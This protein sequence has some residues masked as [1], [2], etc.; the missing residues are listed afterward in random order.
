VR[1]GVYPYYHSDT[2]M[3]AYRAER[4][5]RMLKSKEKLTPTD[6]QKFQMDEYMVHAEVIVPILIGAIGAAVTSMSPLSKTAYEEL[7]KWDMI[8]GTDSVGSSIFHETYRVL[9]EETF[10]DDLAPGLYKLYSSDFSSPVALDLL[11]KDARSPFF[12]DTRTP[13]K[14]DRDAIIVRSFEKACLNLEH[15]MGSKVSGWRWGNIHRI[16]FSHPFG[17][18]WPLNHLFNFGP[19]EKGGSRETVNC[20]YFLLGKDDPYAVAVGPAFRH[21]TDL[22][23]T[24]EDLL[25]IDTGESGQPKSPNYHDQ[26]EM[27]LKGE[28]IRIP[29]TR[30]EIQQTCKDLFTIVKE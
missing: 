13:V 7:V 30:Q 22:A 25:V 23:W 8:A 14:E 26:A 29:L 6:M 20:A 16:T 12:D 18:I 27:W 5:E 3:S 15:R 24:G 28:L 17:E 10:M 9:F 1:E 11:L 4:I 19:N 21:V 2:Y